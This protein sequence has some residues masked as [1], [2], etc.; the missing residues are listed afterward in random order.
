MDSLGRMAGG[1]IVLFTAL[2]LSYIAE[3]TSWNHV[4]QKGT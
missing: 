4:N 2:F 1:M 3:Q